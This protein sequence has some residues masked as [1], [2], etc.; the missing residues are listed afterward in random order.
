MKRLNCCILFS[1]S[2]DYKGSRTLQSSLPSLRLQ[3]SHW[4]MLR[5][6]C[7][8]S[9][10]SYRYRW[11]LTNRRSLT[12][13]SNGNYRRCSYRLHITRL[14]GSQR[15]RRSFNCRL[16]RC[17]DAWSSARVPFCCPVSGSQEVDR[18]RR[19]IDHHEGSVQQH[20]TLRETSK[21][22]VRYRWTSSLRPLRYSDR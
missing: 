2:I 22:E 9:S 1:S 3:Q 4:P 6:R 7:R 18:Q 12:S 16:P 19:G 17:Y 8:L 5:E 13:Y 15:W 11:S 14:Q 10:S 21:L 20:L